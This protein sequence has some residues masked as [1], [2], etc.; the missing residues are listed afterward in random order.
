MDFLFGTNPLPDASPL[1]G[2]SSLLS[3][4]SRLADDHLGAWLDLLPPETIEQMERIDQ[5]PELADGASF[6]PL[7]ED[8]L[9]AL[10]LTGPDVIRV[11]I[12]GQDPYHEPGQAMGLAFSVRAGTTYPPSLRNILKEL[13]ADLGHEARGGDLTPWARQGVLLLNTVLTVPCGKAN[14]HARL[15]WLSVTSQVLDSALAQGARL[16]HHVVLLCW[17]KQALAYA[18]GSPAAMLPSTHIVASTHP[19]PLS[20]RRS[21]RDLPAFMGSRPF[22]TTNAILADHGEEPVD[23]CTV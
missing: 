16:G 1:P 12:L 2:T 22:S 13:R 11:V 8:V 6:F 17:G 23:W 19:S 4:S 9:N 5:S 10:R 7:R 20:A 14:E 21:T 18:Q 15:G 3:I